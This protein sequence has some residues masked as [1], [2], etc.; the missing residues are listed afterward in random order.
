MRSTAQGVILAGVHHWRPSAFE[1]QVPRAL[2][3]IANRPL[4]EYP[5]S[6]LRDGGVHGVEICANSD[7]KAIRHYLGSGNEQRVNIDYYEDHMPRGPAGCVVDATRARS[8]NEFVVLDAAIL[9]QSVNLSKLLDAHRAADAGLTVVATRVEKNSDPGRDLVP[10]G[11]YVFSP[12]VMH[13]VAPGGY[14][15]IKEMLI[16]RLY[17][18]GEAVI[19]HVIDE[20]IIRVTGAGSCF[21]ANEFILE[22]M[23]DD[24][25]RPV[26]YVR[27][28]EALIHESA[29][30]DADA[31][32]VGPVLIGPGT[33][34]ERDTTIVGPTTIGR[35]CFV[36]SG[37]L[38]CRSILWDRAVVEGGAFIDRCILTY[39]ARV[40][41]GVRSA[42]RIHCRT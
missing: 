9:P 2:V 31:R 20:P 34:I 7:T 26:G 10:V 28:G 24:E 16:P 18:A 37:T 30:V 17:E 33:R 19:T 5:L 22:Q 41:D 8:A 4:V 35:R 12:R 39:D 27:R 36:S 6:W 40:E 25:C 42:G 29:E 32:L 1:R 21:L 11:I 23:L 14:Q 3:P 15:D 13:H 38:V